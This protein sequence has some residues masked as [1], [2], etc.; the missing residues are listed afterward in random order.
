MAPAAASKHSV[1]R[2]VLARYLLATAAARMA[3][4]GARVSLVLLALH[5]TGSA[6]VGGAMIAALLVPHVLPLAEIP[7]SC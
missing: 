5:G 2:W 3:D 1:R 7:Q 4:E 6:A